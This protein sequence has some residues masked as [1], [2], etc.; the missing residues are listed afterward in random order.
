MVVFTYE[1]YLKYYSIN[2]LEEENIKYILEESTII[3]EHDKLIK[4]IL[5]QEEISKI[6]KRYLNLNVT[7]EN[8]EIWGNK[9]ITKNYNERE[10]DIV[11]KIKEKSIFF[12]IEHQ[13]KIDKNMPFRI[14]EYS[15]EI[16]R[17]ELKR[18]KGQKY[19][20]NFKYPQVIPI[21]IY[22]GSR[23]WDIS[24][25]LNERQEHL[26]GYNKENFKYNLI[27]INNYTKEE[28]LKENTMFSKVAVLEKCKTSEEII[29][30]LNEI[31]EISKEDREELYRIINYI[32]RPK[33]GNT[34]TEKILNKLKEKEENSMVAE[35]LE[36]E[37][38][39]NYVLGRKEE[40]L[41]I[42]K[43]MKK[44][45]IDIDAIIRMTKLSRKQIESL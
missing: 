37:F 33:I 40:K 14:L 25:S 11:Y 29:L 44:E 22:T 5:T 28:L 7:K 10:S 43:E 18:L 9:Y 31:I 21:V 23:K 36:R 13:S 42:A 34:E 12:L 38:R 4:T 32:F 15:I 45:N 30:T 41:K 2:K 19:K 35:V 20:G 39:K 24:E 27:D 3:K 1:D 17:E 26:E 6:L 8:L 16:M